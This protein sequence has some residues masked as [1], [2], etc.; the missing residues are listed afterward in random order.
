MHCALG[1]KDSIK[2]DPKAFDVQVAECDFG[3]ET[4]CNVEQR[5]N[6][7]QANDYDLG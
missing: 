1:K 7:K 6:T 4:A 5:A 3:P 2:N